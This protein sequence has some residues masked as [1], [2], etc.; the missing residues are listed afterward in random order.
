MKV[1]IDSEGWLEEWLE[2]WLE[3]WRFE[4]TTLVRQ[5]YYLPA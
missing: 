3:V 4:R 2:V 5:T 1:H